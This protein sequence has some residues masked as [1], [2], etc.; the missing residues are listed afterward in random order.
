MEYK[1]LK[2][3]I[4]E[5]GVIPELGGNGVLM[6]NPDELARFYLWLEEN[7][8][9]KRYFEIGTSYG[10]LMKFF[11]ELDW[12]VW[13]CD[14]HTEPTE[15]SL[16][17]VCKNFSH[18]ADTIS[19]FDQHKPYGFVLIDGDHSYEAV[20]RD[21]EIYSKQTKV[22]AFHDICGLRGEEDAKRFWGEI[23][24][25]YPNTYEFISDD[26]AYKAG[27]GVVCL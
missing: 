14:P 15:I 17:R 7:K 25:L 20:K 27:I 18:R 10:G 4:I 26:P 3:R 9:E 23:K 1:E 6:Q 12:D 8:I 21:F 2:K 11:Y 24:I 22:I 19:F 13:G 16:L 5:Q